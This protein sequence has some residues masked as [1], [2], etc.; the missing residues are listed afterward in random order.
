MRPKEI[1]VFLAHPAAQ[2]AIFLRG[3]DDEAK[4]PRADPPPVECCRPLL[5]GCALRALY[6]EDDHP[7]L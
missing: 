1:I 2:E 6:S 3:L 7:D 4:D 5:L